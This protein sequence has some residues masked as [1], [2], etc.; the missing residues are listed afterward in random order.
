MALH[1]VVSEP[2]DNEHGRETSGT[3]EE[4]FFDIRRVDF[5]IDLEPPVSY[6]CDERMSGVANDRENDFSLDNIAD[7]GCLRCGRRGA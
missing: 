2:G 7:I 3:A 5:H 4:P 1:K 6:A